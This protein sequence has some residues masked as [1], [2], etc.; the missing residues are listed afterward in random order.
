MKS[1]VEKGNREKLTTRKYEA[2]HQE[3]LR[4]LREGVYSVG[5]R[6]PTEQELAA[7]FA[8]NRHTVRRALESLG[9]VGLV[10]RA[11]GRG[12]TVA[13]PARLTPAAT[14]I[15]YMCYAELAPG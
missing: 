1:A 13:A 14:R 4:R 8:V 7:D 11:P 2:I 10:T 5:G 9:Q 15:A 12:T 6:M 3:L